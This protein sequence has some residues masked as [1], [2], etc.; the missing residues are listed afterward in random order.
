LAPVVDEPQL[1]DWSGVAPPVHEYPVDPFTQPVT[2]ESGM[3]APVAP[4]Q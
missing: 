1:S 4:Q 2:V 3:Q